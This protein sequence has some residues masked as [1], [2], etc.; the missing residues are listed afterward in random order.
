MS[1][2][3]EISFGISDVPKRDT[4]LVTARGEIFAVLVKRDTDWD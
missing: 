1:V 4:V 3:V 2:E